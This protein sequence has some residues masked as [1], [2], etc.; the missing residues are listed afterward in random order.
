[1]ANLF[2]K[3]KEA[4]TR[5]VETPF[6]T[7]EEFE[8]LIFATPEILE[9]IFLLK[10]QIRG[11]TKQGI[12]D[13]VGLDKDGNICIIEM[14]NVTV[15]A[16][17]IPQVLQ[18]AFWAETNPDSI[19]SLWL[20]AETKPDDLTVSWDDCEVRIIVIAPTILRSTLD[21]VNKINYPVD[22]IEV[23]RWVETG[24]SFLL[25]N[26]LESEQPRRVA[27]PVS[28][29]EIYDADFYVRRGYNKRSVIEFIRYAKDTEELVQKKG[30]HLETKFNKHYCSF[31]AGFFNA[32]GV[33]WIGS[34]TFA[35]FV[36]LPESE[37]SATGPK[38][39]R[40]ETQWKQAVYYIEPGKTKVEDFIPLFEKAYRR[41]TGE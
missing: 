13:I 24:N 20:E 3:S 11:G 39:T 35:M 27:R 8:R 28:G 29:L 36:K 14:K 15:D 40:Y 5:L 7:E 17:I 30:W 2:W 21:I 18:Y 1:M 37:A 34:K 25:V 9:D 12:P 16:S 33:Q 26:R 38:R 31:K 32:F 22:L 23:K 19:K 10:R 41:L 4:T 6:R